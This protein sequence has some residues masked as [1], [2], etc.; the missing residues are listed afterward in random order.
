MRSVA[1][2]ASVVVGQVAPS[3]LSKAGPLRLDGVERWVELKEGKLAIYSDKDA[4]RRK[5]LFG[6][7]SMEFVEIIGDAHSRRTPRSHRGAIA[8]TE[9]VVFVNPDLMNK[10]VDQQSSS[11]LGGGRFWGG[12]LRVGATQPETRLTGSVRREHFS[13][14]AESRAEKQAWK[15]TLDTAAKSLRNWKYVSHEVN[16]SAAYL[17]GKKR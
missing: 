4:A 17:S 15:V 2:A 10:E 14:F 16:D 5:V 12:H 7:C 9:L 11:G 6:P 13:L 8:E 1:L 3:K